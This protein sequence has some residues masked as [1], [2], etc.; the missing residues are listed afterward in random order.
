MMTVFQQKKRSIV[1]GL[2]SVL[3]VINLIYIVPDMGSFGLGILSNLNRTGTWRSAKFAKSKNF[4]DYVMFLRAEIPE[5]GIVVIPPEEVSMSTLS[6]TPAM[7][8]FLNPR[9]IKN[10]TTID[11][12]A[13]FIGREN[14]YILVMGLS[15][16]PGEIIQN[17]ATNIRMY[18]DTWG[19]FGPEDGLGKG[20]PP[21]DLTSFEIL[22]MDIFL[23]LFSFIL[24]LFIGYYSAS[25]ILPGLPPWSRL[26]IGYGVLMGVFSVSGFIFLYLG[27]IENLTL[28]FSLLTGLAVIILIAALL[29]KKVQLDIITDLFVWGSTLD[30]WTILIVMLGGLYIFLA[31][32]AGVHATDSYVLW[33]AKGAGLASEGLSGVITRGT[34]TTVYPLHISMLLGMLMDTFGDTLPAS[35]LIFPVYYLSLLLVIYEF[36]REM[37]ESVL[38]GLSTLVLA[39]MPVLA[40]H[41]RIG[42]A[43]LP[44][45]FYLVVGV[46]LFV[47]AI[48]ESKLNLKRMLWIM[49]GILFALAIW[50]RP[51]GLWLVIGILIASLSCLLISR[52]FKHLHKIWLITIAPLFVGV[53]WKLTSSRFYVGVDSVE[54]NLE[55]IV[56]Q[57]SLSN[58]HQGEFILILKYFLRQFYNFQTWGAVGLGSLIAILVFFLS[59]HKQGC[60]LW[61]LLMTAASSLVVIIA[62]YY[63]FSFDQVHDIGWWLGSGFSRMIM[64]GMTLLW[65]GVVRLMLLTDQQTIREVLL[66]PHLRE[67][68]K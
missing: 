51:E 8:F 48:S 42:Y 54:G 24:L 39:T 29:T 18:N 60:K 12:G 45:T 7:Q 1:I 19:V 63:V 36:L 52:E 9:E 66:F 41:A 58:F 10:C 38:A 61:I 17:Q 31:V 67:S 32:G 44:L 47:R 11:C 23:P 25:M 21:V 14:T 64:P 53:G 15:Q 49:S 28:C 22:A 55:K 20:T 2:F 34:N 16:F 43:N 59:V 3:I 40:R 13:H 26:G 37:S 65:L 27:W 33:G 57:F 4:A 5:T 35:K 50:T 68:D 46:I 30:I 6:N 56:H 62:I